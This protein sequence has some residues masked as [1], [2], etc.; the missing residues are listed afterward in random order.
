MSQLIKS[1]IIY[2]AFDK[3]EIN[4]EFNDLL[5]SH[6]AFLN[7]NKSYKVVIQG[8]ED[9]NEYNINLGEK[10][11][12]SVKIYLQAKGVGSDQINIVS[13]GKEKPAVKGYNARNRRA[14]IVY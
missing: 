5:S 10:R 14:V 3:Y 12:N 9:I 11:A 2:F 1:N 8:H 7:K 4:P 13:Y 6:A